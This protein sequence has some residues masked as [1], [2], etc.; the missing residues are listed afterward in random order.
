LSERVTAVAA[1]APMLIDP[2]VRTTQVSQLLRGHVAEIVTRQGLWL[3][4]RSGDEYEGW[5]H[6]G[7]VASIPVTDGEL[8]RGWDDPRSLSLGCT[9]RDANGAIMKLPLGALLAEGEQRTAGLAMKLEER[10]RTFAPS[11]DS[12]T[13]TAMTYFEGTSYEWGGLTPWG[14]D[15]S[16]LVQSSFGLHGVR[17]PRDAWMQSE[18]GEALSLDFDSLVAGDL[19][20][21]SDEPGSKISHVA[22][23]LGGSKVVHQALGRGGHAID[24]LRSDEEYTTLLRGRWRA[25]RRVLS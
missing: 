20:F 2:D 11:G 14:A 25:A 5:L 24:D 3:R 9:V 16:G 6:Q 13:A 18:T 4:V 1:I 22:I 19:L 17:V 21:F 15:C 23:S 12:I 7:Y 8:L 10:R